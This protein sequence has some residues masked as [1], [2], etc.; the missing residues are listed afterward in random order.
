MTY[1]P[2][3]P[4]ILTFPEPDV[5]DCLGAIIDGPV[6]RNGRLVWKIRTREEGEDVT[7]VWAPE[8][9][10]RAAVRGV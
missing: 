5:P 7:E 1:R 6:I 9:W 8:A 3:L 10:L 4:V 2:G